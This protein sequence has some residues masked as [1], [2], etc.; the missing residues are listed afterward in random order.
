MGFSNEGYANPLPQLLSYAPIF[1]IDEKS[2]E[3]S[4]F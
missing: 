3:K 4:I 1:M 2:N